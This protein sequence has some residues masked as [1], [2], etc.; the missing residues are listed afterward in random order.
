MPTFAEAAQAVVINPG[1]SCGAGTMLADMPEKLRNEV[2]EA[3]DNPRIQTSKIVH[4]L[5]EMGISPPK[6]Y[7]MARHRRGACSCG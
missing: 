5:G 1:P 2:Q 3:L 4:L 7:T 6:E